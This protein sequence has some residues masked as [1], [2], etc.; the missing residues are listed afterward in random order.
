MQEVRAPATAERKRRRDAAVPCI[1][2]LRSSALA[3]VNVNQTK[4]KAPSLSLPLLSKTRDLLG[5]N[6]TLPA[7]ATFGFVFA[8]PSVFCLLLHTPETLR[9]LRQP[10]QAINRAYRTKGRRARNCCQT[11]H[12]WC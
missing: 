7:R 12:W 3:S 9:Q 1:L 2:P 4:F 11:W 8:L 6:E 5:S 10:S